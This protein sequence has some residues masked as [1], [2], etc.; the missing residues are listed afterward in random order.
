MAF[1]LFRAE[2]VFCNSK[3]VYAIPI[4]HVS[5][6]TFCDVVFVMN[7]KHEEPPRN[8]HIAANK[9]HYPFLLGLTEG[10]M[11]MYTSQTL[12]KHILCH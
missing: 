6:I 1:T 5:D 9:C 3:L 8:R 11:F 12:L 4:Y 7:S 10:G 2:P